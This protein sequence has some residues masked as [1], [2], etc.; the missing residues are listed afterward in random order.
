MVRGMVTRTEVV[1]VCDLCKAEGADT[2]TIA[3]DKKAVELEACSRCWT[4]V[5]TGLLPTLKAGRR[6]VSRRRKAA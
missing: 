5:E 3:L 4:K 2:H 6:K 1:L